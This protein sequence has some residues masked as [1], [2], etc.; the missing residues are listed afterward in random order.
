VSADG[1]SPRDARI[2][3]VWARNLSLSGH[4]QLQI[5]VDGDTHLYSVKGDGSFGGGG[6]DWLRVKGFVD[7][8]GTVH[9]LELGRKRNE[10]LRPGV[11][12]TIPAP[13]SV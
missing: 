9:L 3:L 4:H 8:Q 7:D 12:L 5:A 11:T 1:A 13:G 6:G 2:E 10:R